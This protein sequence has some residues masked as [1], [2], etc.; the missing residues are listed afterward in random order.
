MTK[1]NEKIMSLKEI[2]TKSYLNSR[3]I[4]VNEVVLYQLNSERTFAHTTSTDHHQLILR[5]P[6]GLCRKYLNIEDRRKEE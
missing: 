2:C 4:L 1:E 6:H 3:V 5:H